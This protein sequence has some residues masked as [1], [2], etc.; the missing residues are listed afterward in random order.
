MKSLL[1]C[2]D[3][4]FST[5]EP[6]LVASHVSVMLARVPSAVMASTAPDTHDVNALPFVRRSQN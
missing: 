4:G 2:N 3:Y 5:G 1:N 6:V